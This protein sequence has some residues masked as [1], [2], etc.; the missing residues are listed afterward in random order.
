MRERPRLELDPQVL[1][2]GAP[3]AEPGHAP[4]DIHR[5]SQ[6]RQSRPQ[7]HDTE[8]AHERRVRQLE[9][10]AIAPDRQTKLDYTRSRRVTSADE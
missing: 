1:Q 8:A 2:L 7:V 10:D 4:G 6:A 5:E 3:V 9:A